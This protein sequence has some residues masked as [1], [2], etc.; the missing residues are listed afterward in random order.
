MIRALANTLLA[1]VLV[2]GT[3]LPAFAEDSGAEISQTGTLEEAYATWTANLQDDG[4]WEIQM[5]P[6]REAEDLEHLTAILLEAP[7]RSDLTPARN[8]GYL[9]A[10]ADRTALEGDRNRARSFYEVLGTS[11]VSLLQM[12]SSYML[13]GL[14]FA[15]GQYEKSAAGYEHVCSESAPADWRDHACSMVGLAERLVT[16]ELEGGD[17]GDP[18]TATP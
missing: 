6:E 12:W 1:F 14:D 2:L 5:P 17:H 9:V 4:S 11:E 15:E 8:A 18:V 16:L 10:L 13:A 3:T 7:Q